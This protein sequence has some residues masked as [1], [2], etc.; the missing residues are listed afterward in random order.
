MRCL[1]EIIASKIKQDFEWWTGF[2]QVQRRKET[3]RQESSKVGP[4]KININKLAPLGFKFCGWTWPAWQLHRTEPQLPPVSAVVTPAE[5]PQWGCV[6]VTHTAAVDSL[7]FESPV[8]CLGDNLWSVTTPRFLQ[9]PSSIDD[10]HFPVP[11][12]PFQI[13]G[14][15]PMVEFSLTGNDTSLKATCRMPR[16]SK[17]GGYGVLRGKEHYWKVIVQ[18]GRISF[19]GLP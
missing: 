3:L 7:S 18:T 19:W 8:A 17:T 10:H 12:S 14:S 6:C 2:D 1:G 4:G 5:R 15:L 9:A 13:H 11:E 16:W